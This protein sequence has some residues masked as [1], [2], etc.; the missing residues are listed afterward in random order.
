MNP[1]RARVFLVKFEASA[2]PG[3]QM[4]N[5]H[6]TIRTFRANRPVLRETRGLLIRR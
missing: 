4:A 3:I 2:A 6:E 5:S 1:G